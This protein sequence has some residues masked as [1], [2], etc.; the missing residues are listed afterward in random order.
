MKR[1]MVVTMLLGVFLLTF[2]A[3][4]V[5]AAVKGACVNCHTMHNSQHGAVVAGADPVEALLNKASCFACHTGDNTGLDAG[6][7]NGSG[8]PFVFSTAADYGVDTLAGGNFRWVAAGANATGHNVLDVAAADTAFTANNFQPPGFDAVN[9]PDSEGDK[10]N[11]G[12]ANWT[13]QLTCAGTNG[14]HG[15]HDT[16]EQFGAVR[17]AHH[18]VDSSIDGLTVGTSYRFLIGIEGKEDVDW[19]FTNSDTDHNQYKGSSDSVDDSTISYLCAECHGKFHTAGSSNDENGTNP[20]LRHPTDFDMNELGAGTEYKFYTTYD[21]MVPVASTVVSAVK[22][23]I[24]SVAGDA[25]VTCISCHRA[26]G[27]PHEDLLRWDYTTGMVA[28]NGAG[29]GCFVCHTT[30]D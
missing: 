1:L 8:I 18:L 20:W 26:H 15:T 4:T 29:T 25:I 30:K 7:M 11:G 19:E 6:I 28:G 2:A 3:G 14:C 27:S 23:T 13:T 9:Y 5:F 21:P 16:T 17:G 10:L 12:V 24:N 22:S